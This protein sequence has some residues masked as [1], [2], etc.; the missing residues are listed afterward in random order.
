V[1]APTD[2]EGGEHRLHRGVA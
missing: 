1:A 2:R